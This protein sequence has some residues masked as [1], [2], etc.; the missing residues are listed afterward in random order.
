MLS[1]WNSAKFA[2]HHS[3]YLAPAYRNMQ[4]ANKL[5]A[6]G[7]FQEGEKF[8]GTNLEPTLRLPFTKRIPYP[9]KGASLQQQ[10]SMVIAANAT[11]PVLARI[12]GKVHPSPLG[13]PWDTG[14]STAMA[15][16]WRTPPG[17]TS[18]LTVATWISLSRQEKFLDWITL[19]NLSLKS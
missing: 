15:S 2:L 4:T 13:V 19:G 11:N 10:A 16:S 3:E 14:V 8:S 12:R 9:R 5:Q 1:T 6:G 18:V 17:L 7:I